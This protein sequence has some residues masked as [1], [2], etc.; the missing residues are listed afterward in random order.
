MKERVYHFNPV[1]WPDI[2]N[3]S[4][5]RAYFNGQQTASVVLCHE[6]VH[7]QQHAWICTWSCAITCYDVCKL[8]VVRCWPFV[9]LTRTK[10]VWTVLTECCRQTE[11]LLLRLPVSEA[12]NRTEVH[13]PDYPEIP[14]IQSAADTRISKKKKLNHYCTSTCCGI[15]TCVQRALF[16]GITVC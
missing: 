7:V 16:C 3:A 5:I 2:S 4:K 8:V 12:V 10:L 6:Q 13:D 11:T 14:P 15:K 9:Q 1:G